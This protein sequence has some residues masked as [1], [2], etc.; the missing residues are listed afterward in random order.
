MLS[1][2][3]IAFHIRQGIGE[4]WPFHL[5]RVKY[6]SWF[7]YLLIGLLPQSHRTDRAKIPPGCV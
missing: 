4:L 7:R 3:A 2:D 1:D 6:F 5:V